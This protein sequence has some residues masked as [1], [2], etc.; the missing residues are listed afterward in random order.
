MTMS[1]RR[2]FA[3]DDWAI[4]KQKADGLATRF[5]PEAAFLVPKEG[6]EP[7]RPEGGGF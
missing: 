2:F 3:I 4:S 6:L 1:A 7:S 5:E